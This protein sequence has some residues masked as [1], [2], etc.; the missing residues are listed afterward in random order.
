[1][2]LRKLND[3]NWSLYE[4]RLVRRNVCMEAVCGLS[5]ADVMR[6]SETAEENIKDQKESEVI[7]PFWYELAIEVLGKCMEARNQQHE[8]LLALSKNVSARGRTSSKK[9]DPK[10]FH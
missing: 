2:I 10:E 3:R 8:R 5:G 4:E 6:F 7:S 1:M 9:H